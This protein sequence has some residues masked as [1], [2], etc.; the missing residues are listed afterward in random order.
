MSDT[1]SGA[2][3]DGT[4][5][6]SAEEYANAWQG[7]VAPLARATGTIL[8]ACDPGFTLAKP[9]WSRS[10]QVPRWFVEAFNERRGGE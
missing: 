3:P 8:I 5:T 6:D 10:V 2:L 7:M 1:F 9:D 4:E